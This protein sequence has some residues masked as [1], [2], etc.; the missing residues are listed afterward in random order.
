MLEGH[1]LIGDRSRIPFK[2]HKALTPL[3]SNH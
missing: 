2:P 3:E 1:P